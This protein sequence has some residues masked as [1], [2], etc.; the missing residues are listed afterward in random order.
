MAR[1]LLFL[2]F[3]YAA[4]ATAQSV[5]Y[6][7]IVK[8]A[9]SQ[10]PTAKAQQK[11]WLVKD[12]NVALLTYPTATELVVAQRQLSRSKFVQSVS[13]NQPV[14][15][16]AEPN[17]FN[18]AEQAENFDRQGYPEAWNLTGGGRTVDGDE[19]VI[20]ILDAGFDLDHEDIRPNL[21]TN[22]GEVPDDGIDNDGN[23]FVD[24]LHGWDMV[25]DDAQINVDAHGTQV[26][27][28]IG[29]KGNNDRGITGTNW[30]TRLMLFRIG[31][32]ADIIRAYE[33][34]RDQRRRYN[35]TDGRQGAF[36]VVTNASFGIEGATCREFPVWGDMYEQLGAVGVLTAAATANRGWNVEENGDMP[37]DCS[38]EY[39]IGVANLGTNDV[40]WRSSAYGR[41]SVDLAATGEGSFSTR[42]DNR[43]A[44]F[45]S[46]SAAAPYVTGAIA[47]LYATPC[48]DLLRRTRRDPAGTALY[49]RSLL[50]ETVTP[51]S[52]IRN[53]VATNGVLNVAEAQRRLVDNCGAAEDASFAITSITPNPSAGQVK[54]TTN[55]LV[56]SDGAT[57]LVYDALGRQVT[58]LFPRRIGSNP[59]I[60]NADLSGM[61][62]GAYLLRLKD[63]GQT[64]EM[65][66]MIR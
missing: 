59:V 62:A 58:T 27:G 13:R 25:D 30:D 45:G 12:L 8:Y 46:T 42:P 39:L 26:A 4:S 60:L 10:H 61:P 20:A 15:P 38:S 11:R 9:G 57:L 55:A 36:V 3:T 43:Y 48:A 51:N 35:E 22:D 66:L 33:Y 49:L 64:A 50:L 31:T 63:R 28:L 34:I 65:I 6:S 14:S 5:D 47:L 16:R 32:T 29:A 18:Y 41:L 44:A 40:L 54:L 37:T 52:A 17:D 53:L 23:G 7:L 2:L 1:Y 21:W 19:I 24:D 56:L